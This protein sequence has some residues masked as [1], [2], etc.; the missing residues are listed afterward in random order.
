MLTMVSWLVILVSLLFPIMISCIK[1]KLKES[2]SEYHREAITAS[3]FT[4]EFDISEEMFE[5]FKE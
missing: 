2:E 3:D 5:Y 1:R 4:V